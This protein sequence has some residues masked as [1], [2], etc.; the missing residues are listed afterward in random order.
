[1]IQNLYSW[2]TLNKAQ[3]FF[4][5]DYIKKQIGAQ[6]KL[7][8]V[9]KSN[10]YGHGLLQ[11]AQ[12]CQESISIDV[13][14]V[15]SLQD[16]LL[17]SERGILKPIIAMGIFDVPLQEIAG[18][19][20][21]IIIHNYFFAE[22]IVAHAHQFK[23]KL[24]VHLK[25]DT[26]MTR[27]GFFSEELLN[28][29]S[30]LK[31]SEYISIV[32]ICSHFAESEN[33]DVTFTLL[34]L[35]HFKNLF[36]Q[37]NTI[38]YVHISNTAG[39]LNFE[40]ARYSMVRCGGG[41]YGLDLPSPSLPLKPIISWKSRIVE[42]QTI[43]P[44]SSVGYGRTF[45]APS[46]RKIAIVP[47]GYYD[48]LDRRLSNKGFMNIKGYLASIVGRVAMNMSALDVTQIPSVQINDEV[49]V[50]GD[51]ESVHPSDYACLLN[52]IEYEVTTRI[53]PLIKRVVIEG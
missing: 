36:A 10:A 14:V 27:L 18:K 46:V 51:G 2:I 35:H 29:V 25:F 45:I 21:D 22:Q 53:N 40:E 37:L 41:L 20:I 1:M 42:L 3:F 17:L 5:A 48:G 24:R 34:Q 49:L 13:L 9:I 15:F 6:V 38:E 23:Q 43:G 26:G 39:T 8:A 30:L 7:A 19:N 4:N 52:T 33:K 16:A 28:I 50:L 11:I 44:G 47:L 32:G 31:M 12:L